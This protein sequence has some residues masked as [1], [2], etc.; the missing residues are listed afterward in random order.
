M[1]RR[2]VSRTREAER[3]NAGLL[4]SRLR[5]IGVAIVCAKVALVPL[6][7]DVGSDIPFAVAKGL[8]SH[9][10]AYALTGVI[11][12]LV[13]L[14][15]RSVFV[16]SW[17]HVPVL[18]FLAANVLATLFAADYLLALYG[19]RG[20]MVGL[21]T[22]AD[23]VLL[24]GAIVLLVR[25]RGDAIAVLA[26]GFGAAVLVLVYEGIQFFG[27]D[28]FAWN[29]SSSDRPFSS[30]GQTTSLAEELRVVA[31][32][33]AAFAL[34]E[35]GLH[36]AL[37]GL[38][39]LV[40]GLSV[41][42]LVLTRTRSALIGLVLGIAVLLVLTWIAHPSR[43]A[44]FISL[45]GAIIATAAFGF[46]VSFTPLGGRILSTVEFS[47][48]ADAGD[49]TGPR[50]EQ[51]AVIRLGIYQVALDMVK[52]RPLLGFGPDNFAVGFA[53]YRT[54]SEPDELELGLTTS[55]HGW[56]SQVASSTGLMG[57]GSFV[58]MAIIGLWL[59]LRGGFRPETWAGAGIVA[60]FL[61][62]GL[63]TVNAVSTEWLLW[64]GLGMIGVT[65]ARA[66]VATHPSTSRGRAKTP[67]AATRSTTRVVI[68][69]SCAVLG[70]GLA[71]TA[72]NALAASHDARES[73]RTRL[74]SQSQ[75]AIDAG[76]RATALDPL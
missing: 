9:A 71:L 4:T 50:L 11:V 31:V 70:V 12:G 44:R 59:T 66:L 57:L 7:F 22:I 19:A 39:L 5:L 15:G 33:A 67:R 3:S 40:S 14:Y 34:L 20:R 65:T 76:V 46:A 2:T 45:G 55:A 6:V 23:G 42:G 26:S 13:V 47:A 48:S 37:R 68:A 73:Q 8:L 32:G 1:T 49:E 51:S 64:A 21:A 16:W 41:A 43:R 74:A 69:L 18:A 28:P 60:A 38:L 10:L 53:K 30:L 25:T 24:Y 36:R 62:D 29:V 17:L 54:D 35:T 61:G 56:V 63:T 72:S 27:R 75:Q 52:E 58:A